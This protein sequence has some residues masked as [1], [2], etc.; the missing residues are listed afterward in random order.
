MK[1]RLGLV[2]NQERC[3]GCEACTVA[4]RLENKSTTPWINVETMSSGKK[5][6]PYGK[7]PD[8]RMTFLPRLCNH[9]DHPPC[10][11]AC[12]NEAIIKSET[13]P[14]VLEAEKCDGCR[15]CIDA[16][17]YGI[18]HLNQEE[19]SSR[20]GDR[21]EKCNL[22]IHRIEDDLEPFC[23]TCCEGQAI[24]FGDLN[25]PESNVAKLIAE[26]EVFRL[27]PESNTGPC[28]YYCPALEPRVI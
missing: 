2:I 18:I 13:G 23:V 1:Q 25:N 26:R 3:I 20:E 16:C 5:D 22:C 6:A 8:L 27:K 7:F 11:D 21:V 10:L 17:P 19:D 28:V 24:H 4:C 9:C 12:P 15:A 14:V